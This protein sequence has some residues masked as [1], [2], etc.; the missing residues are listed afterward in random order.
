MKVRKKKIVKFLIWKSKH[1]TNHQFI[2]ILCAIIGMVSGIMAVFIKKLTSLIQY[3]LQNGLVASYHTAFYF[4]FP[5]IGFLI[6]YFI[7][8]YIIKKRPE[9]GIPYT[10]YAISRLKGLIP[11]KQMYAS[12]ITA[13]FTVG[14]GGSAGL[15]G[16]MVI[17]GASF[18]SYLSK[19]FHINQSE[20][21]LLI[22]CACSATMAAMFKAP[23]AAIIF[24]IEVFS[25][26]LTL[27]SL[28]P[29]ISSSLLAVLTSYFF[30]GNEIL[31]P[32]NLDG[33]FT[34][35][36]VPYYI[37][38]GGLTGLISIYFCT[39]YQQILSYF[40]KM[41]SYM[42][43]LFFGGLMLGLLIFFIP[44]LYGEGFEVMNTLISGNP[45][46]VL[47]NAFNWEAEN[48]WSIIVMMSGLVLFKV[49]AMATTVGAGGIGGV[50]S[51]AL[52]T[53]GI[54]GNL[55]ARV[56]NQ[57]GLFGHSLPL[58]SFTLVAMA[59]LV[60]GV[61]HAPLTAIFLIAELTGGYTLF[62]PLMIVASVSFALSKYYIKHSL[63]TKQ[64]AQEGNLITHDKD[65]K[66]L[67]LMDI[68]SVIE[69]NLIPVTADMTLGELIHNAVIKSNRNVFPVI[70]SETK[71][72][73]GII[74]LDN[75]RTIM[76][77]Q[78]L[79]QTVKV[80]DVMQSPP[81]IIRLEKDKMAD[82]MDK[83]QKTNA[84][85]L[86]V[87]KEG[88][89]IGFVSKSKLLTAYRKNLIYFST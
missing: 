41:D 40:D 32:I 89:Y 14:F 16:P 64:L 55:F 59:G 26:D 10:L 54:L 11:S 42:K 8:K 50:F 82:I 86:P 79:Y 35:K 47:R 57:F 28:L 18:S 62:I 2:L 68:D 19:L 20:R 37:L 12:L 48:A 61:L 80:K 78:E 27:V 60:A 58:A 52:F 65:Q 38:L 49:V 30:L 76:F 71:M 13:P 23:V 31:I 46:D 75:I 51:P 44:P 66:I 69:K 17:S 3:L 45:K 74:L 63:Y 81:G 88:V 72:F 73:E 33:E 83:F 22:A 87:V 21:M 5:T 70:H 43:R 56:A 4:F 36:D 84:W 9:P 67:T 29:L 7:I 53:G 1:L 24:A 39:I 15:E 85:N 6:V 34:L 77:K 25:L